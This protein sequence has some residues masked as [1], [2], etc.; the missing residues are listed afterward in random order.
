MLTRAGAEVVLA[1]NGRVAVDALRAPHAHFDALLMDLQMPVMDGYTAARIIR[2]ELG[3]RDLPIIAVSAYARPEDLE[4]SRRNGMTGHI[5]KPIDLD[6]L[7][8]IVSRHSCS[9]VRDDRRESAATLPAIELPGVD[10]GAALKA[11]GG[12][13]KKYAAI[14]RQFVAGHAE[15]ITQ[16]Q[17]LFGA[18]DRRRAARLVHDLCGMAS[19]VRAMEMAHLAAAAE[20]AIGKEDQVPGLLEELK[21]AM[22]ALALSID[23]IDALGADTPPGKVQSS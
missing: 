13:R 22:D 16:A 2:D 23:K 6:E 9:A 11:F 17:R 19:M 7:L 3:L 1:A 21:A 8:D 5:V 12:D 18:G 10:V 4:K 15:D 14:L 20:G